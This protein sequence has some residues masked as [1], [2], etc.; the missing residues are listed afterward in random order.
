[1][2]GVHARKSE[3]AG[4]KR[5]ADKSEKGQADGHGREKAGSEGIKAK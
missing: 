3:E 4:E 5:D 2:W 1:M